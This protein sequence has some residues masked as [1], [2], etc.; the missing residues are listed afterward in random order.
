MVTGTPYEKVDR[1][2]GTDF[3]QDGLKSEITRSFVCD[4]GFSSIEAISHGYHSLAD[5][6][7][8]MSRPFADVHIVSVQPFA[9]SD[10][11]HAVVMDRRGRV[12]DPDKPDI[13][14]LAAYYYIV[15]VQGFW[16]D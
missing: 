15:R 16:R 4:Q 5:S 9:D 13:K 12:Y 1:H 10:M 7:K 11:N 2:F 14:S 6:N 8:R 3:N